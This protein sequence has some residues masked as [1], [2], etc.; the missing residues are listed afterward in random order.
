MGDKSSKMKED[1]KEDSITSIDQPNP[2][3][4][5]QKEETLDAKDKNK[6]GN[7]L[8]KDEKPDSVSKSSKTNSL[9]QEKSQI[10]EAQER[11]VSIKIESHEKKEETSSSKM[12]TAKPDTST[13]KDMNK[14]LQNDLSESNNWGQQNNRKSSK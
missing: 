9:S 2:Q 1:S 12:S 10:D 4:K 13:P 11:G 3:N 6:T 7:Q 14:E 8:K 5:I